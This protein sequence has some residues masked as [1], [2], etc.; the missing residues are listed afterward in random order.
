MLER[1]DWVPNNERLPVLHYR[2][3]STEG[4]LARRME[5][6]FASNGWPAQWRDGVYDYHHYHS[7]AHEVLGIA[8]GRASL[9]LG[10][11]GG[12]TVDVAR[13]DV[14]LLPAG[15][16]HCRLS[17]SA[18]F[19][20]VGAYPAG[21]QWDVCTSAPDE[22]MLQRIRTLPFPDNDPVRGASPP[23][24]QLWPRS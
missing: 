9:M 20:V 10:G 16:G 12:R 23:L 17:A 11:P 21:Q 24:A 18:D 5:D 22:K 7:T 3:V 1:N 15:T 19:L 13:G 2:A 6:L 14:V 4:D 8:A